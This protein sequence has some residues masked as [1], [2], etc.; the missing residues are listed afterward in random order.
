MEIGKK[1][2]KT[3]DIPAPQFTPAWGPVIKP[4]VTVPATPE[5]VPVTVAR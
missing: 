4:P 3:I 5:K 2:I 1:R